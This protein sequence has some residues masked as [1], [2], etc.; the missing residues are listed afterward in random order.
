M[1]KRLIS[2]IIILMCFSGSVFAAGGGIAIGDTSREVLFTGSASE[3]NLLLSSGGV[4][5][6]WGN[7]TSGQCG[8]EACDESTYN[9]IDFDTDSKIVQ[10]AAGNNFSL[11][12]D[13]TG[14]VWGWGSNAK[15]QLGIV[16]PTDTP[17]YPTYFITPQKCAE[18]V[19]DIAAGDDFSII[20][21]NDGTVYWSGYNQTHKKM[22]FPDVL[23]YKPEIAKIAVKANN[24]LALDEDN[25][26][27][28]WRAGDEQPNVVAHIESGSIIDIAAGKESGVYIA[29]EE[30]NYKVYTFG[31]NLNYQLGIA[32]NNIILEE[33]ECILTIPDASE[34]RVVL[35]T[36]L[37]STFV[38]VFDALS[39]TDEIDEYCFGTGCY[40]MSGAIDDYGAYYEG[41]EE[42]I[43]KEPVLRRVN[44][45]VIATGNSRNIAYR[46]DDSI[47]IFG[48]E[49]PLE[50]KPIVEAI[51]DVGTMYEYQ[52]NDSEYQSYNVNFVKLNKEAFDAGGENYIYWE[53][54]NEHSFNA[55][56]KDF[57]GGV[58][59]S[60]W[61]TKL[62]IINLGTNI[63]GENRIIG[64]I[65][66]SIWNF[67]SYDT[68]FKSEKQEIL[69]GEEDGS[70]IRVRAIL[71]SPNMK[72]PEDLNIPADVKVFYTAPGI[73]TESTE[74]GIYLYGLPYG[75]VGSV[76]N[77][78][79]NTFDIVLTG[80][81]DAD[82]DCDL[83][84]GICYI[85]GQ[86]LSSQ[87]GVIG[88]YDLY[89]TRIC[90]AD[91]Y[92]DGAVIKSIENTPEKMTAE[93][94]LTKGKENGRIVTVT[95]E[96][97]TFAG[98]LDAN[99]WNIVG[100]DEIK[101][102][103]V[104]RIDDYRAELV[105]SGNSAD[106]YTD[107]DIQIICT[108]E[109]YSD[110]REYDEES[111][112]YYNKT[113]TSDNSITLVKQ[114]RST[115]GGSLGGSKL[116]KPSADINSGEVAYGT[117]VELSAIP[118][119]K[120][121]YTTDGTVPN[122]KSML[123][124]EPIVVRENMTIK[125]IAVLGAKK[126][127]VQTASY[128]VKKASIKLKDNSSEIKYIE[129]SAGEKIKPDEAMTRYEILSALDK[130]FDIEDVN[131][132][133]GF[134]DV[135]FEYQEIVSRFAGARL[136]EGYPDNS[137]RGDVGITR[138]EFVK[139]LCDM[140]KPVQDG[141]KH[142][143]DISGHWAEEYINRFYQLN[144]IEGYPDGTF[145]PDNTITKAEVI[146]ILNRAAKIKGVQINDNFIPDVS[147]EHWAYEDIYAAVKFK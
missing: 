102:S 10:V 143:S 38:D 96:G 65:G 78:S 83:Q 94:E 21:N 48:N 86:G 34:K 79:E 88:D 137:F 37:Y 52:Y 115:V 98:E 70:T 103:S 23:G 84:I 28:N 13:E 57:I 46:F 133:S 147:N 61:N 146:T 9:Y 15:H 54:V 144:L 11:A 5:T 60:S 136:I 97:G 101:V 74:L 6:A 114:V 108:G 1:K 138:A 113:L 30:E 33:P 71:D 39:R 110:S 32:D 51:F 124:S 76:E 109:E 120:I 82:L 49:E 141:T 40:Y 17:D 87:S 80:N 63:T 140:L 99:N 73:I 116:A 91:T 139:I 95:L 2:T 134:A 29:E 128:T 31:E 72:V 35:N 77:I 93:A 25:V 18:N 16:P 131:I 129:V 67:D 132:Q 81:S 4:V 50:I 122:D 7:N 36:G 119:A 89:D 105:L 22:D 26:V 27:Y 118:G 100:S 117:S 92:I 107:T 130:L 142:F 56:I 58:R 41:F 126:S 123:Y 85:Y 62:G 121:Y 14:T 75:T 47:E 69:H 66:A 44:H 68:Y 112:N 3:H 145:K 104:R 12:L 106:K 90:V 111:G 64:T 43:I 45:Q 42:D 127:D 8:V 20:L 135:A 59:N 53:Y 125:Y 24:I 19:K 55:K